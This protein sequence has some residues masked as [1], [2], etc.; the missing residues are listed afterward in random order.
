MSSAGELLDALT[1]KIGRT[2]PIRF[3]RMNRG[4]VRGFGEA[5]SQAPRLVAADAACQERPAR[6]AGR[7]AS[8]ADGRLGRLLRQRSGGAPPFERYRL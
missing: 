1:A 7:E 4:G 5:A 2:T 8:G 6:R 3:W